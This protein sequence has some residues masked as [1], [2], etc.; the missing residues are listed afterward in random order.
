MKD[1]GPL[2]HFLA[3]I[4]ERRSQGL[5]LHQR[6]YAI[7]ILERADMSDCKPCSTSIDTQAKLYEDDGPSVA[8]ATS[9]QSLTGVLQYMTFSRPDITYVV[10]QCACIC[11][12]RRSPISPL[13]SGS[14]GSLNYDLLLRPCPTSELVVYTD[15]DWAGCPD[16][17]QSTSGYAVFLGANLVSWATKHQP[18]VSR[19]GA[20]AEYR[21]V[22]NGVTEPSGYASFSSSSTTPPA[23]R[24][25]LHLLLPFSNLSLVE[26]KREIS[27][28]YKPT[29]VASVL[30]LSQFSSICL[31]LSMHKTNLTHDTTLA[32]VALQLYSLQVTQRFQPFLGQ[33]IQLQLTG[34]SVF[35]L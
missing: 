34:V 10:Q 20:E 35:E 15:I 4:V 23:W 6:Q 8:D 14:C 25:R 32:M 17:R 16:T 2:H 26:Q 30:K 31:L 13:S 9:Y 29:F 11:T 1:L 12:P 5:F 19:S 24:P 3:I 27:C 7:D 33:Y 18:V 28:P 22:A 21:A